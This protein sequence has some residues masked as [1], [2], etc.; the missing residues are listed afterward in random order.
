MNL[1]IL[2]RDDFFVAIHKP[3]GLL[4]HRSPIDKYET[5][6]ALQMVRNQI[7]QEVYPLHRLDRPTSG[8]LLFGLSSEIAHKMQLLF[9][10]GKV[11]KK[12]HAIVRGFISEQGTIDHPLRDIKDKYIKKRDQEEVVSREAQTEFERLEQIELPYSVDR[13]PTSRYSLVE[14]SPKTGRRHQLRRHMKHLS[15]P[16]IGD[17]KYGK[18][19]HNNFFREELKVSGLLLS[20]V[21]LS[22]Q[23]PISKEKIVIQSN[24]DERFREL[25]A[26][27]GWKKIY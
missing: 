21:N 2:Y 26:K 9:Q 12:Y 25:Y 10:E 18:S 13:Y 4:V 27:F 16:I 17:P 11:E 5:Q 20:A 6:F 14:L 3:Q 19:R 7:N 1:P 8:V 23:H 15:H 22:F 24:L